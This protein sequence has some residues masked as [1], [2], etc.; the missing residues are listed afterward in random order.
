MRHIAERTLSH[1]GSDQL[2]TAAAN[3]A[4][5]PSLDAAA[6]SRRNSA[7]DITPLVGLMVGAYVLDHQPPPTPALDY[8]FAG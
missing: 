4:T 5:R 1:D 6:P 7:G 8:R 2:A 3:V